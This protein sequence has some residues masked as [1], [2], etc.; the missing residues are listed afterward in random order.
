MRYVFLSR[1]LICPLCTPISHLLNWNKF[2][3]KLTNMDM[4]TD[5]WRWVS[6]WLSGATVS[7]IA[8]K[9][10]ESIWDPLDGRVHNIN[11]MVNTILIIVWT[12]TIWSTPV[13][14]ANNLYLFLMISLKGQ[15]LCNT[16]WYEAKNI[17][18]CSQRTVRLN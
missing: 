4:K 12:D 18:E 16:N 1:S 13:H 9:D 11:A 3:T 6:C 14:N 10:I 17:S 8:K 2:N 15:T 7:Q 5:L